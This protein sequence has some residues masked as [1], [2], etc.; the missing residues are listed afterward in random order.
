MLTNDRYYKYSIKELNNLR[1][2]TMDLYEDLI[3]NVNIDTIVNT[4]LNTID[5]ISIFKEFNMDMIDLNYVKTELEKHLD[6]LYT[7]YTRFN[8]SKDV[9]KMLL[10][11][12]YFKLSLLV[13]PDD[14]LTKFNYDRYKL[15][16]SI[17][18]MQSKG[19]HY[20]VTKNAKEISILEK[21][22]HKC[23]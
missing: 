12:D 14:K 21:Q 10:T 9:M 17:P 19:S 15:R 1:I 5:S 6:T 8:N 20:T 7:K 3:N 18:I 4:I 11:N 16:I 2:Y 23:I 13:M 22:M